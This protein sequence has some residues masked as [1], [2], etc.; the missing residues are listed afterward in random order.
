MPSDIGRSFLFEKKKK[1]RQILSVISD[2][3]QLLFLYTSE[4]SREV[5][6]LQ[7]KCSYPVLY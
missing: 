3:T 6:K 2:V 5:V 1:K 4:I 7:V